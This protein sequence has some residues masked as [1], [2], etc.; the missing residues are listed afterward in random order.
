MK[1]DGKP[2]RSIWRAPSGEVRIIDQ[3]WL[4][5]ELRIATLA[6]REDFAAAI[7][8]MWVRG[9][10]LI[11]ATAAYG[12]AV[13]MAHDPSDAAL[14]ETWHILHATRPT[15]INLKWALDDMARVLAPLAP[16]ERADAAFA[17]AAEIC[18]QDVEINRRIGLHGLKI[19]REIARR[20]A[21]RRVNVLTHCN[22]GWPATVD[23]GTATAPIYHAVEAG[24]NV[25]VFVD[26]TRPRNQGAHLTSWE[27]NSHGVS[28]ELIVD[29]A[30]GHLMQHGEVDLVIVGTDRTTAR[31]DVCNKIGTYLK[32]LAARANGIPFYVALPSPTI[33]WTV[34]D[35]LRDI[36]IEERGG[37]E[38]T[39]VQGRDAEGRIVSVQISP[40]GTPARNP[41]FDVTPAE[42]VTALITE[43]GVCAA[44]ETAMAAMFPDLAT[45]RASSRP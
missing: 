45:P 39:H 2:Y 34:S 13:Q 41:A 10:P 22:A 8:E 36:P 32:A 23:W 15:A 4:P 27:L 40:D 1:I 31:G 18:D 3:R 9:A 35:G 7:Q 44:D 12:V 17:R 30:G 11:G 20:K 42:L 21:G 26:E 43:R 25:H 29:N 6:T 38:V 14:R 24:I 19:I 37:A 16:A 28:H 33:D 5:H